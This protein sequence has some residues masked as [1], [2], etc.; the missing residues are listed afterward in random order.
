M[1]RE[2]VV[3]QMAKERCCDVEDLEKTLCEHPDCMNPNC[4]ELRTRMSQP[5]IRG[6]F[7]SGPGPMSEPKNESPFVPKFLRKSPL[8]RPEGL[9]LPTDSAA[10]NQYPM[11]DGLFGYFQS[12]LAE[13][14]RCSYIANEQ[15]NPGEPM[16]W[17]RGKSMD[18]KN[19]IIKHLLDCEATDTDGVL[20]ATKLAWRSLALLQ[21][22]LEK[23]GAPQAPNAY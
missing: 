17:A 21:E 19:K 8:E 6:D 14:A 22:I 4:E 3:E 18:H 1:T 11:W 12:A 7:T 10:R 16:H 2:E 20:H 5:V 15:H 13:V 23:R 9:V